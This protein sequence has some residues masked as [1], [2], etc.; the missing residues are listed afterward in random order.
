ML[1]QDRA[2]YESGRTRCK[3]L[4]SLAA[5]VAGKQ[6][7]LLSKVLKYAGGDKVAICTYN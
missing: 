5:A 4:Q 1:N 3:T 2:G 6:R 7:E